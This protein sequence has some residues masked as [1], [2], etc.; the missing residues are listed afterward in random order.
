MPVEVTISATSGPQTTADPCPCCGGGPV[1][2]EY[3]SVEDGPA[4]IAVDNP[5]THWPSGGLC[6]EDGVYVYANEWDGVLERTDV[7]K[8]EKLSSYISFKDRRAE[9]VTI[10]YDAGNSRWVMEW[11]LGALSALYYKN[12]GSTPLGTYDSEDPDCPKPATI[13]VS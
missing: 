11:T 4:T 8:W 3:G 12:T 7:C 5:V 9:S 13:T 1:G 6:N 10:F 2:C